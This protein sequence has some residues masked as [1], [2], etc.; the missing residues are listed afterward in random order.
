MKYRKKNTQIIR[1]LFYVYL[2]SQKMSDSYCS[3][4]SEIYRN[5]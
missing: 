2:K 1:L 3:I 5:L 4:E